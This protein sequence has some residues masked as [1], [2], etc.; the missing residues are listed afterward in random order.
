MK[1]LM[2][3]RPVYNAA[4]RSRVGRNEKVGVESVSGKESPAHNPQTTR[5]KQHPLITPPL[6]GVV[7]GGAVIN[8][9][10]AGSRTQA[11]RRMHVREEA[12]AKPV[13]RCE[14]S[15]TGSLIDAITALPEAEK[16]R[17]L[18]ALALTLQDS[19]S[20][21]DRNLQMWCEAL[22]ESFTATT[23]THVAVMLLRRGFAVKAVWSVFTEL[24]GLADLE[25]VQ[26]RDRTALL[27]LFADLLVE[28][29]VY[30]AKR[31][32]APLSAKLL[33]SC[34]ANMVGLVEN[35]FPGY[36]AAGLLPM[37]AR[38]MLVGPA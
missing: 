27:R 2:L 8:G 25:R 15:E 14:E 16:K 31:S 9:N 26:V 22:A 35:A 18:D 17:I 7:Y 33:V 5:S 28:H 12:A 20:L 13:T 6:G 19:S 38:Q 32:S 34:S 29:A 37:V 24:F 21:Q 10:K 1:K 23:R 3:V 36:L 4:L 11:R 30:V